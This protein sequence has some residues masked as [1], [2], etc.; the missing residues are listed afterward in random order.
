MSE[1]NFS[2]CYLMI[3]TIQF[4]IAMVLVNTTLVK[5]LIKGKN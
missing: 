2:M 5:L 1:L 3:T 4:I